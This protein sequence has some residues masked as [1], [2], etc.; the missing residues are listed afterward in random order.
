M[1]RPPHWKL[2]YGP[3]FLLAAYHALYTGFGRED[4]NARRPLVKILL[5]LFAQC[6]SIPHCMRPSCLILQEAIHRMRRM[7]DS[8]HIAFGPFDGKQRALSANNA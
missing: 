4:G 7:A 8:N 1:L 3:P 5:F 6:P 2:R